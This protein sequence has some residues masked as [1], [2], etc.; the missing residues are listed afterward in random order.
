MQL[1]DMIGVATQMEQLVF[2]VLHR[3]MSGITALYDTYEA[4]GKE[5]YEFDANSL[6]NRMDQAEYAISDNASN[7]ADLDDDIN[8]PTTGV[9][10]TFKQ[11][12]DSLEATVA[13]TTEIWDETNYNISVY[14][15]DTPDNEGYT[16][17]SY[18]NQYYLN[19][20]TG[21]VYQSNGSAWNYVAALTKI[22]AALQSQITIQA[23]Q[24]SSKVTQGTV[25]S[26]ISQ[27]AGQIT[28]SAGR[29]VINSGNFTLDSYGSAEGKDFVAK[30]SLRIKS[31]ANNYNNGIIITT[32][33]FN[34]GIYIK[35]IN[36]GYYRDV[37][38]GSLI[39]SSNITANGYT[40]ATQGWVTNQGYVTDSA[41]SGYATQS[42]VNG[43]GFL[44]SVPSGYVND[45]G[46]NQSSSEGSYMVHDATIS[47]SKLVLTR[48]KVSTSDGRIKINT[49]DLQDFT[50]FYMDLHPVEFDFDSRAEGYLSG[51]KHH[52]GLIA[53]EV[54]DL[55]E[56][57]GIKDNSALTYKEKA[58]DNEKSIINDD[59][60]WGMH[61]DELH[62]LHIQMIQKQQREIDELRKEI[63]ELKCSR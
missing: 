33:Y 45:V 54:N 36:G 53:Q 44:T 40:V 13:G 52:Y 29:L 49:K 14:G 26:E 37:Y 19:Q 3:E 28:L 9:K 24:I 59:E 42:W 20:T 17:S 41:L 27:E 58:N 62:A 48:Y 11:Q 21:Y 4:N 35:D 34:N 7:I 39:A 8:N 55:Y 10:V 2:P 47:G 56:K 43:R 22:Q 6:E 61:K 57:Y 23:G 30:D 31:A 16:P 46:V 25:S 32:D 12:I 60:I 18:T 38:C 1:G 51:N 63:E 5:Y 15:Y 50:D